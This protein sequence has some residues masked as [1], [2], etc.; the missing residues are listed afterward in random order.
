[1]DFDQVPLHFFKQLLNLHM[2]SFVKCLRAS[3]YISSLHSRYIMS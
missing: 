3:H 2:L 1:V